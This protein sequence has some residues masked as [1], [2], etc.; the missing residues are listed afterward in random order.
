MNTERL[1]MGCM[2]PL[3][4]G[5]AF[6]G[7]CRYPV[8]GINP[9]AYLPLR[10][11]LSGRYM[12][13]RVLEVGGDSAVYIGVDLEDNTRV[14]VREFFP[15]SLA[16][17]RADSVDV[18]PTVGK[19]EIFEACRK[20]FL[21][22]ARAVGRLRDL[23]VVV[24]SYDIFEENGTAYTISE[25]CE[26]I[27]LEKHVAAKG[28]KLSA[29]E[30]RRLFLPLI[31]AMSQIH[32]TGVLHLA[33]SPKNIL[34]D[35]EGYLR[36]KNFS[37]SEMRT[38]SGIGKPSRVAGCAAPEQYEAGA[39][40]TEAA[41][42]YGLAA[43]MVFAL[44][45]RL[46]IEPALR[47]RKKDELALPAEVANTIP[48]Y[49]KESLRSALLMSPEKRT[50]NARQLLDELSAT[51][52]VAELR[53][54]KE[55]PKK[56]KK[57]FLYIALI[58]GVATLGLLV[59][60]VPLLFSLLG[61][62]PF[63]SGDATTTTMQSDLTTPPTTTTQPITTVLSTYAVENLS[64]Q[65]WTVLKKRVMQGDVKAELEGYQYSNT[66]PKGMVIS[67]TPSAGEKVGRGS[68]V[69][70]IISAGPVEN[71]VPNVRGWKEEHAR[72]YLEALG[73][74]V[75]DSLLLQ[76]PVAHLDPGMVDGTEPPAGT[77]LKVGDTIRLRIN[78]RTGT[79]TEA[80]V[81]G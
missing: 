36:L 1:C 70:V 42:V 9:P 13:G 25:Y 4:E 64:G 54:T 46:P 43:S 62:N 31:E 19:E 38:Q 59:I 3:N 67:Q 2:S 23:P 51:Q 50:Q 57:T 58:F 49:I 18:I 7:H 65:Q 71:E 30:V 5:D 60:A 40:C 15:P 39:T 55:A 17:R 81:E 80:V 11:V 37:I 78:P 79:V 56:K 27:S 24:P 28:G 12:V 29:E 77:K 6:C 45:G 16:C 61:F 68:I 47:L 48:P 63:A 72:A 35:S 75:A 34:V 32:A 8:S 41:D 53:E 66:V 21:T 10:T 74:N 69:K 52:A 33:L 22:L 14:T 44:T 20:K 73:Y 76:A 26:G